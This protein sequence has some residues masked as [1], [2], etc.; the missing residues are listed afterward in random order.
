M[1]KFTRSSPAML[2]LA[3]K[4]EKGE[5]TGSEDPKD[6]W[7][8]EPT[9]TEHKLATFKTHYNKV[10]KD[11][12]YSHGNI[13]R[14]HVTEHVNLQIDDQRLKHLHLFHRKIQNRNKRE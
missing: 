12:G 8:S 1:G 3:S 4:F 9:F 5:P 2:L 13:N 6:V 11:F 14:S 7:L 10:R